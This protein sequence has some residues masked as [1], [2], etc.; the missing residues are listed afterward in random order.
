MILEYDNSCGE[1]VLYMT[2]M[3]NEMNCSLLIYG[4]MVMEINWGLQNY[5]IKRSEIRMSGMDLSNDFWNQRFV[6]FTRK[7]L[8]N[9]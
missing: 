8:A 7:F 9:Y 6:E 1:K 4:F 2:L 5:E 3:M